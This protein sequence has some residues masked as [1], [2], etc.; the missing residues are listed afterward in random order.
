MGGYEVWGGGRYG[1][2][3]LFDTEDEAIQWMLDRNDFLWELDYLTLEEYKE[4]IESINTQ[5]TMTY[6]AAYA[7]LERL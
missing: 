3:K 4:N 2:K 1:Y 6:D 7:K 5:Q